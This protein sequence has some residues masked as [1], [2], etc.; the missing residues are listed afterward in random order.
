MSKLPLKGLKIIDLTQYLPGPLATK[1]LSDLGAEVIKIESGEG[2]LMRNLPPFE[3]KISLLFKSLNKGKKSLGLNLQTKEGHQVFKKLIRKSDAVIHSFRVSR[4]KKLKITFELLKKINSRIV[5]CELLAD[6]NI[7]AGHD[8]NFLALS[9]ALS[10]IEK[11]ENHL[12][13]FQYGDLLGG[14]FNLTASFLAAVIERERTNKPQHI[15]V[16]MLE[17]TKY[18]L[19]FYFKSIRENETDTLDILRGKAPCYNS[20]ECKDRKKIAIA[21]LEPIFW[22]NICEVLARPDL[23]DKQFDENYVVVLDKLLKKKNRKVWLKVFKSTETT[24][25]PVLDHKEVK[26]NRRFP[27]KFNSES[28]E[29]STQ[30]PNLGKDSEEILVQ[31][32]YSKPQILRLRSEKI[33][34]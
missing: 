34:V 1:V 31:L 30:V 23:V 19:E 10:L 12:P 9:G 25:V 5:F 32:G 11:R 16:S 8:L 18:F 17:G 7:E 21:A 2:D 6:Y 29:L 3:G 4:A 33:I 22:S 27:A 15:Q 24:A 20:Y 14:S 26:L 13:Y 28:N